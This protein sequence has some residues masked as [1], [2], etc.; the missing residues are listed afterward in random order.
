ML[1]FTNRALLG[2]PTLTF[3]AALAAC[4][5]GGGAVPSTS[6]GG[7]STSPSPSASASAPAPSP[8]ASAA[9]SGTVVDYAANTPIAGVP[10][11]IASWAPGA[12][13]SQ[14]ATTNSSGQFSFSTTA[15]TYLMRIGTDSTTSSQ[16]TL[17]A[18]IV[19]VAGSNPLTAPTP[20]AAANVTPTAAQTSGNFRLTTLNTYEQDCL[21]GENQ[22]RSQASLG[23][24]IPDEYLIE[25]AR[26]VYAE[27]N[28]QN[29]D[30]PTPLFNGLYVY[31][32]SIGGL[33]PTGATTEE[34]YTSC[35]SW[36]GPTY[37]LNS[38]SP[39]YPDVTN[40]S[41]IYYGASAVPDLFPASQPS[42][43]LGYGAQMWAGD[44]R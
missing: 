7:G 37:S 13:F 10:I 11:A 1:R 19:L 21:T 35:S 16:T 23:A 38:S 9:A 36:T 40:A 26:A 17:H 29:T 28:A 24:L 8:S 30:E 39:P 25:T 44:P 42:G 14:V 22:S 43:D 12:A 20:M 2:L 31:D 18:K 32:A 41:N 6:T 3:C 33:D 15:G 4:G 27:E 5:G 34:N